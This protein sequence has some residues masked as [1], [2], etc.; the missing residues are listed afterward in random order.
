MPDGLHLLGGGGGP[1]QPLGGIARCGV[2]KK[3]GERDDAGDDGNP[4]ER[5]LPQHAQHR[6]NLARPAPRR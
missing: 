4:D 5:A 3:E 2:Q 1:E 6:A